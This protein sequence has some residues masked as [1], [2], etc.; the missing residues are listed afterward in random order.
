MISII[1]PIF[2]SEKYLHVCLNS[3][4][5]Q[6]YKDFE[7][8][9]I[10]DNSKDSSWEILEFFSKKDSRIKIFKNNYAKGKGYCLK[11][12]LSLANGDYISFLDSKI[13]LSRDTLKLNINQIKTDLSEIVL[14]KNIFYGNEGFVINNYDGLEKLGNETFNI[15]KINK[16]N[17]FKINLESFNGI[18]LKSF[19]DNINLNFYCN[20]N[21]IFDLIFYKTLIN[22]EKISLINKNLYTINKSSL[23]DFESKDIQLFDEINRKYKILT[24][25]LE[26]KEIYE[27]YKQ[28]LYNFFINSLS[29][30][31][32]SKCNETLLKNIKRI[33]QE[34]ILKYGAY[35]DIKSNINND[36]L[37]K[38][39]LDELISETKNTYPKVSI[40][41]PVYN[42]EN[43]LHN[44]LSSISNQ[45]FKN[46]EI[47]CINDGSTDNSS[48]ILEE[49]AKNDQRISIITQKNG[50]LGFARNIGM[51]HAKGKY[52]LFI[53]SDD[54]IELTAVEKSYNNIVSNN[55]DLAIFKFSRFDEDNITYSQTGFPLDNEFGDI[56]YNMFTFNYKDIKRFVLN[57][58]FS[59]W[60]KIYRKDFL[61]KFDSNFQVGIAYE[62]VLFHVKSLL[63][64][65]SIS[66]IPYFLYN[67]R[68][69][70]SSSIMNNKSN[71]GDIFKVCDDVEKYL[72]KN[73]FFNEFKIEFLIFKITQLSQYL[74]IANSEEYFLNVKNEFKSLIDEYS[75]EDFKN[76][77]NKQNN[78]IYNVLNSNN[79]KEYLN[80]INNN[81]TL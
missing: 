46:I 49:Y 4:I 64:A 9:C 28:I 27:E 57:T 78:S 38:L 66:F 10:D 54:F 79:N 62:D 70:N 16:E 5:K 72:K 50:G 43:Y 40:I 73:S 71:I 51:E 42:V 41:V 68:I 61:E 25:F 12:G 39:K 6:T 58:S 81:L 24:V 65:S 23:L 63:N 2:N 20:D 3:I 69:S 77:P 76:L 74:P 19:L 8:I 48:E 34:L 35:E 1:I 47:I 15:A 7:I 18:Y 52:I 17:L 80:K 55:S 44:C 45:T 30:K 36:L 75:S 60:S 31:I 29:N 53:D 26:N 21:C 67:Y 33:F 32:I 56:N 11:K 37:N 59:T 13:W 14:S 22:A